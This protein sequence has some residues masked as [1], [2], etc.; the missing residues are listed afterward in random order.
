MN[1][2]IQYA[3]QLYEYLNDLN[4]TSADSFINFLKGKCLLQ[5]AIDIIYRNYLSNNILNLPY[6][7][8]LFLFKS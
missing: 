1:I 7:S 4:F 3:E 8:I 2:I 6:V 5:S